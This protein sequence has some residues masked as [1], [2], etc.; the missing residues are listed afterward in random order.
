MTTVNI[1]HLGSNS[2]IGSYYTQAFGQGYIEFEVE[3]VVK[4][5][6]VVAEIENF[7]RKY[8]KVTFYLF[9]K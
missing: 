5:V 3:K 9:I 2:L 1:K 8:P 4:G 7:R 6:D